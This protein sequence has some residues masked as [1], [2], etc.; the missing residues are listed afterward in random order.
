MYGIPSLP[1]LGLGSPLNTGFDLMSPEAMTKEQRRELR[2]KLQAELAKAEQLEAKVGE[3]KEKFK[4]KLNVHAQPAAPSRAAGFGAPAT[5]KRQPKQNNAYGGAYMTE[6]MDYGYQPPAAARPARERRPAMNGNDSGDGEA[7]AQPPPKP[8][9]V[10]RPPLPPPPVLPPPRGPRE[11]KARR[12]DLERGKRNAVLMK[13]CGNLLTSAKKKACGIYFQLPVDHVTLGIPDYPSIVTQPMDYSTVDAKLKNGEYATPLDFKADMELIYANCALYNPSHTPVGQAGAAAADAFASTWA[14]SLIDQ[15]LDDEKIVRHGED[16][17][18]EAMPEEGDI[19]PELL[20]A[21]GAPAPK[22]V[23][24]KKERDREA[25]KQRRQEKMAAERE[26]AAQRQADLPARRPKRPVETDS[27]DSEESSD[28]DAPRPQAKR[29]A[30]PREQRAPPPRPPPQ[31]KRPT[32]KPPSQRA[33]MKFEQKRQ[34]S[35]ALANLPIARQ[36]R[37]VQ[38]IS[39]LA[40]TQDDEIE[41]DLD[42]MDNTTLWRLFDYVFPKSQQIAMGITHDELVVGAPSA[43]PAAAPPPK[44]AAKPAASSSDSSDTDSSSDDDDKPAAA[45]PAPGLAPG[46]EG[47]DSASGK[48]KEA[49]AAGALPPSGLGA[50][51]L[52]GPVAAA[53]DVAMADAPAILADVAVRK[54]VTIQNA[55]SWANFAAQ[56]DAAAGGTTTPGGN[57]T[58]AAGE[59]A[60]PDALWSEFARKEAEKAAREAAAKEAEERSRQAREREEAEREAAVA[61]AKADA[62]AAEA[63]AKAAAEAEEA[64]RVAER[65]AARERARA[66]LQNVDQTV[67]LD[68]QRSLMEEMGGGGGAYGGFAMP[69]FP[70]MDA[71]APPPPAG[72]AEMEEGEAPA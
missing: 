6:D 59:A 3:K 40:Q 15:K 64:R 41:I 67:N 26:A 18:I 19:P 21:P 52:G 45:A 49:A 54:E 2:R 71:P 20:R 66:E 44:P 22:E 62:E 69:A 63:A 36:A 56:G 23:P 33:P 57:G 10:K 55:S 12:V 5:S 7:Y 43:A 11:A 9:P 35:V 31:P 48:A 65:E 70:G 17:A 51:P 42:Q 53:G 58:A 61:K 8:K 30:P 25:E 37:V 47:G 68:E 39:D 14:D 27:D 29:P 28:D 46:S 4:I 72:D 16:V 1:L 13:L 50:L 24:V 34:L 32:E 38:I 60:I